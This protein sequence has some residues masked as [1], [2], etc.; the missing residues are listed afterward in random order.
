MSS[1]TV[2]VYKNFPLN[3]KIRKPRYWY[4]DKTVTVSGATTIQEN[5]EAY[6][7]MQKE[8]SNDDSVL[9]IERTR[10][11][12]GTYID[13]GEYV[14]ADKKKTVNGEEVDA[15]YLV[16]N[17]NQVKKLKGCGKV[18]SLNNNSVV[19][20]MYRN[21]TDGSLSL[22]LKTLPTIDTRDRD[23]FGDLTVGLNFYPTY[24]EEKCKPS[25]TGTVKQVTYSTD[26]SKNIW[27][28]VKKCAGV[29]LPENERSI[30][31]SA[32]PAIAYYPFRVRLISKVKTGTDLSGS[33]VLG[34]FGFGS[35]RAEGEWVGLLQGKLNLYSLMLHSNKLA[36]NTTYWFKLVETS[37]ETSNYTHELSYIVDNGYTPNTL[38][39]DSA[40][41]TVTNTDN[42]RYVNPDSMCRGFGE[43][44]STDYNWD[45]LIDV[46]NTWI[47]TGVKSGD[48]WTYTTL[49]TPLKVI[50]DSPNRPTP[51]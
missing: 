30:Y 50:N 48:V 13:A 35:T 6:A 14:L 4:V 9:K 34:R 47:D 28:D 37:G 26:S 15:E 45:G 2:K 23:W 1:K 49:W 5:L 40:W 29:A 17:D 44:S 38:P 20:E 19:Y 43:E 39:D 18:F 24:Y 21:T 27:M 16:V 25:G 10:L 3:Y 8:V 46:T 22:D 41:T 42:N 31:Q 12:N 51:M 33:R 36:A 11:W 7:G 32:V